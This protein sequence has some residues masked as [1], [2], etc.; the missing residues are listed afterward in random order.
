MIFSR[1]GCEERMEALVD[2]DAPDAR[3]SCGPADEECADEGV[4]RVEEV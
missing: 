1:P 4:P 2:E 3:P